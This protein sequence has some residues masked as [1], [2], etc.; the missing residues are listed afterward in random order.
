M[1]D[2]GV[3]AHEASGSGSRGGDMLL[4]SASRVGVVVYPRVPGELVGPAEA[5][6]ASGEGAGVRLL[7]RV[8]ANMASL[9]L[10]AVEGLLAQRALVRAREVVPLVVVRGLCV[11]EQR[12]HE[13]HGGSGHRRLCGGVEAGVGG[14]GGYGGRSVRARE[15]LLWCAVRSVGVE[16]VSKAC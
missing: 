10:E 5:L 9:V 13:A 12:R 1:C 16:E 3:L 11:L 2:R 4:V 8:G 15:R 14:G 7:A 6:R